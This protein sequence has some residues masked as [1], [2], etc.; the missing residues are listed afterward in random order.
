[1]ILYRRKFGYCGPAAVAGLVL[2]VGLSLGCA[3]EGDGVVEV[4]SDEA[5]R[6]GTAVLGSIS[7]VDS[8]NEYTSQ[9]SFA[10]NVLRRIYLRLAQENGQGIENPANFEPLLAERWEDSD[11]GLA[12]TFV[13]REAHWSDGQPVTAG[14]V[15]YTW[16]AQTSDDVPW[17]GAASKSRITDVEV[18]GPREVRFHF[19]GRYPYQLADAVEGGIVPEHVFG[20]VPFEQWAN[21]D[22]SQDTVGSGPFVLE[23]HD[24]QHEIVLVRNAH[25]F[26]E[27]LPLLDRVVVRIVPDV[28]TLTTLL[29][30]GEIDWID[31]INPR[32]AHR[33]ASGDG[34]SLSIV[35]FDY[36]NYDFI[37]WNES[38]SPLDSAE[39]RRA[40]TM[41][42]DRQAL[43]E[44]LLYGYGSVSRTPVPSSWWGADRS[45]EPLPYRPD[46]ARRILAGLG[47]RTVDAEGEVHE[48]RPLTLEILTNNGNRLRRD[49]LIKIQEQLARVG[50]E[51][52]VRPM[53]PKAMRQQVVS[54]DF[55]G[56]L[57]G[58][59]FVGRVDLE[60]LLGS[61][62][63][64]PQGLNV[65]RYQSAEL[66][67]FLE[68]VARARDA[69]AMQAPLH[70]I[71]RQFHEDQ[72]YTLLYEAQR[73]AAHGP[74]LRGVVVDVPSDPLTRL[75]R[76]W[77]AT[78]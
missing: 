12:L 10:G 8:W 48:G 51:A 6:G 59:V 45:I 44:D 63:A 15:R 53:E 70:G 21:H 65:V 20:R 78:N 76:F 13:L 2:W 38:R 42:I 72:P 43:V 62:S 17:V 11:D 4:A 46:E 57:G 55:D 54:G 36:P 58:W 40:L 30:S 37:G 28:L 66:D 32:D 75:E 35:P 26:E 68:E 29:E 50:V 23:R 33:I 25:Y 61:D 39:L 24:P 77:V 69:I 19:D 41:A 16:L 67:A 74:R 71:Q 49:M 52:D 3:I 64:P 9:H 7:D 47:Y 22:W 1:M 27:G 14:D 18:L 31:G 73:I 5:R 60:P 34:S 56:F